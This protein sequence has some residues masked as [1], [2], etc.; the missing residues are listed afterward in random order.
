MVAKRLD[1]IDPADDL[2]KPVWRNGEMLVRHT[3]DEVR[4]RAR[5]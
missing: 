5:I 3:F 2:L 4:E 1:A